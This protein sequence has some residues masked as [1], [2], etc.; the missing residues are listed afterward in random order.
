MW[1]VLWCMCVVLVCGVCVVHVCVVLVCGACVWCMCVV[2]VCGACVWC[3][4][5]HASRWYVDAL[6]NNIR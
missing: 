2:H 1:G 5:V 6:L 4:C 3:M